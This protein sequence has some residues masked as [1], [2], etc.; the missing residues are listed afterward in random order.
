MPRICLAALAAL[1][2]LVAPA[3][4]ADMSSNVESVASIPEMASAI[5]VNFIDDTMFVSTVAGVYAYDVSDPSAPAALGA[6]PMYVWENEDMDV[7]VKRKRLFISRDPRGFT[8]PAT[9]GAAFPLGGVHIIDVSNPRVMRQI[10]FFTLPAGHTSTCVNDCDFLWTGGP[11]ANAQTQGDWVGR[12]IFATDVSDPANPKQCPEPID[13]G[14]NDGVTDYAHD[15]QVDSRGVAWVSG[16]GG[17]RGYWTRGQHRNPLTGNVETATACKPVPYGGSGTPASGTPSRFM[18][19]SFRDPDGL[20]LAG[21]V[22]APARGNA[23]SGAAPASPAGP[24]APARTQTP[25]RKAKTCAV[26]KKRKGKSTKK[27][28]TARAAVKPKK[29]K[30]KRKRSVARRGTCAKKAKPRPRRVRKKARARAASVTAAAATAGIPAER[31]LYGT[32]EAL[33]SDCKS[34]G[35]F[36]TYD[37][38]GT[39]DGEGFRDTA[40]TKHRMQVLDTW[41]PE[42]A[43]GAT[44][45]ASAH[46]FASRGDGVLAN[47]FYDQGVRFLD[48]SDP[49]DIR[50]IGWWRPAAGVNTWATYWHEGLVFVADQERGIEILRF[51]GTAGRAKAVRAPALG[52]LAS[53]EM[54][55]DLG[56]LCPLPEAR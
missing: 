44:G 43:E 42:K 45:C 48:A 3:R 40:R 2:L 26:A 47:A 19:N 11:Y 53:R 13:T 35:R 37:L 20:G 10:G 7:D 29:K 55:P 38:A 33:S 30:R 51:K 18:H 52:G 5:A 56:Y 49:R 25:K 23:A 14:R 54:D 9:P 31:I 1:L 22:A 36:A 24:A 17:V 41:T 32:E 28:T 4:A 39:F 27:R 50:Q 6:F 15:V 46:Y 16:A 8:S 21:T 34:S 12:P